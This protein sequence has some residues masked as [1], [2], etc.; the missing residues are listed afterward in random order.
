MAHSRPDMA[1]QDSQ[2]AATVA[3]WRARCAF[4]LVELLVVVGVM[5][6]LAALLLPS[7][8]KARAKALGIQCL[9]NTRQLALACLLYADDYQGRLPYNV[10]AAG[11][12]RG[13]AARRAQNWADGIL[14]WE[15]TSDNTNTAL[16]AGGGLGSY[17]IATTALYVC[18]SD[19]V[20]STR[21]RAAGWV[22]RARSY[23]MNAM[24]GD[25]GDAS[26]TGRNE[27]NPYY[28]QFFK[29]DSIPAPSWMF[30]FVDE[31]PDSLNDGYFLNRAGVPEW[32]DL[33]ASYHAGSA[34]FSFADGHAVVHQ[35]RLSST[36]QPARPDGAPLPLRLSPSETED[37]QWVISRMSVGTRPRGTGGYAVGY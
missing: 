36:K 35:W 32:I 20:L 21:Q 37:W 13:V 26:A 2:P 29:L 9:G 34:A 3:R 25:A 28:V 24:M 6:V 30:V 14:D 4:T 17:T 10:G 7:L 23:S 22:R 19:R 15:L 5:G 8:A 11:T 27:N 1:P 16:L 18:P 12:T 31:H 33:P